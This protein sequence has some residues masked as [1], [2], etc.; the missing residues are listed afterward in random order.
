MGYTTEFNG[1]INVEPPLSQKEIE[2]LNK[3]AASRR[4]QRTRGPY[5]VEDDGCGKLIPGK[6]NMS[7]QEDVIDMNSPPEGQPGLWCQWVPTPEGDAIEWDGGEKFYSSVEW[8]QYLIDHFIGHH[9]I[10]NKLYPEVFP[11]LQGHTCNGVIKAQG[12]DMDDRWK[13]IVTD[14][15]ITVEEL[16]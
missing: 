12:E 4:V 9:P 6:H 3:F 11:F 2:F 5:Y 14:N 1:Q 7:G 10:A 16:E 15:K 8:M 13:L